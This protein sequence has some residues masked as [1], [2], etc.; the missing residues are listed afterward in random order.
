MFSK[1]QNQFGSAGLVLSVVAIVLALGGGAYA[2]NHLGASASKAKAGPRGKTGKTGPAGPA[3]P[4][5]PA[6]PTG[7]A[8]SPGTNGTNGTNGVSAEAGTAFSGKKTVGSVTCE[9]GGVPVKSAS[10]ETAVCNGKNGTTGF[11]DT[12]PSGSSESGIWG[13]TELGSEIT[14]QLNIPISFVIPLKKPL[15]SSH[16]HIFE[17]TTAPAGCSGIETGGTGNHLIE[18]EAEPGNLCVYVD[19]QNNLSAA[20]LDTL[21]LEG[22]PSEPFGAGRTGTVL[23][24]VFDEVEPFAWARGEWVVTAP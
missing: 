13:Q 2:A 1:L 11:T 15:D 20:E 19:L 14:A 12:L 5:G 6:G 10:P 16:V 7:P 21:N 23:G 22:T 17:G 18:L 8:G 3:G 4:Q 24:S 9:N